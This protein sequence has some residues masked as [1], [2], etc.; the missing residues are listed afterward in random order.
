M[1]LIM[2]SNQNQDNNNMSVVEFEK[3]YF[4]EILQIFD[5]HDI[6]AI[7]AEI[8]KNQSIIKLMDLLKQKG[9]KELVKNMLIIIQ[10]LFEKNPPDHYHDR[11]NVPK[12]LNSKE[13]SELYDILRS[14]F[15][16]NNQ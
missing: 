14:E 11:G 12:K 1:I 10:A 8:K 2:N 13:K 9:K 3:E 5:I 15:P 7:E 16:L 6:D 4:S